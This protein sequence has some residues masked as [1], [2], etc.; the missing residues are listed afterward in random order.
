MGV[1]TQ[2]VVK[3]PIVGTDSL[4]APWGFQGLNSGGQV[5]LSI[6]PSH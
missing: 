4:L 2:E 3:G 5:A 1:G 6:G